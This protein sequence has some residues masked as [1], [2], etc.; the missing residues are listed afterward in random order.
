MTIYTIENTNSVFGIEEKNNKFYLRCI[1]NDGDNIKQEILDLEYIN[2][3]KTNAIFTSNIRDNI[4][5]LKFKIFRK[6]IIC[7]T[8]YKSNTNYLKTIYDIKPDDK[9]SI[10]F[11]SLPI[12]IKKYKNKDK[13]IAS[14]P[15]IIKKIIFA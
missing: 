3:I 11:E 9:I 1:L 15:L 10:Q 4:L 2:E 7:D 12:Y 14:I 13:E 5:K 6:R 8:E